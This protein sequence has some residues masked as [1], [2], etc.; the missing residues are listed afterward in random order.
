MT[1]PAVLH[2]FLLR[3]RLLQI[4]PGPS[5]QNDSRSFCPPHLAGPTAE[6]PITEDSITTQQLV[7]LRMARLQDSAQLA[8]VG[9]YRAVGHGR[10]GGR[11]GHPVLALLLHPPPG[12]HN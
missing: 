8:K 11:E 6:F 12:V 1:Q 5:C 2:Q 3:Q 7:F 10:E 9:L 4:S